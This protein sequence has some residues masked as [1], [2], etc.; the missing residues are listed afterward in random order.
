ME[1]KVINESGYDQAALGFSLSYNTS[2]ERT[3]E[4][5]RK[6]AFGIPGENKFLEQIVLWLDVTAPRFFWQEGDTYR[7]GVSKQSESTIH[8]LCKTYI[9]KS[10]FEYPEISTEV[11]SILND[12]IKKYSSIKDKDEKKK[13]F[14]KIKNMLPEGFL[15]RRIWMMSYKTLQNIYTQR[16]NHR[17][18][19][20]QMFLSSV[21]EQIEHPEF[22]VKNMEENIGR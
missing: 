18:P 9:T 5:L 20:W 17:L 21:M 8:T 4:I 10:C 7:A 2:L 14:L 1:I 22:I 12:S 11:T 13:V 15:Q 16:I 6:Y 19:Q 3:K